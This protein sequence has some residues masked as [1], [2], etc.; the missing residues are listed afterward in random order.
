M[1]ADDTALC[2]SSNDLSHIKLFMNKDLE[3]V[4]E[5]F[6]ANKLTIN[7]NKTKCTLFCS[8]RLRK[9]L[10]Y[11]DIFLGS[12]KIDY[13]DKFDYLGFTLDS[14]LTFE[15]HLTR[16][17]QRINSKAVIFYKIRRFI[18]PKIAL[19]LYKSYLLPILEYGDLFMGSCSMK[20]VAALQKFQNRLL[21]LIH[22]PT[23]RT[24]NF[25]LHV[26]SKLLPVAYRRFLAIY[27]IMFYL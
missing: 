22:N 8:N 25:D 14:C 23:E 26:N 4:H 9:S 3:M 7:P 12:H 15:Q 24:S 18:N 19:Q 10:S 6:I 21:R 5:W 16:T 2:F 27:R 1:Y 17:I 20:T 11:P 13:V